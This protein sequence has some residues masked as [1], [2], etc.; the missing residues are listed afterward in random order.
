MKN[1]FLIFSF[2]LLGAV[3]LSAQSNTCK[4]TLFLVEDSI[5]PNSRTLD[6]ISIKDSANIVWDSFTLVYE[7]D[8]I[9]KISKY[10]TKSLSKFAVTKDCDFEFVQ[11]KVKFYN[12]VNYYSHNLKTK[13][14]YQLIHPDFIL[15]ENEMKL[16]ILSSYIKE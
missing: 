15:I 11:S 2:F 5:A 16:A 1:T 14:L 9:V 7:K 3:S 6:F 13:D 8:H 12:S 4:E 10:T